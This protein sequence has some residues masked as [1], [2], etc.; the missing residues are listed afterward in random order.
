M[1]IWGKIIGSASG[2]AIGGPIGA[3]VGGIAGHAFDR[4]KTV[5]VNYEAKAGD[6]K[7]IAFTIAVIALGAKMAKADGRVTDDEIRAFR[8]VFKIP[9]GEVKNVGRV[10]NLARKDSRGFEPY[11]RQVAQ[12]F[13]HNSAVLEDLLDGLFHI[14]K[15][16]KVYDPLE[17]KFLKAVAEIFGF[18][19]SEFERIRESHLGPDQ[20]DPYTILGAKRSDSDEAIKLLYRHLVR[21]HHPDRLIAEGLPQEFID[22]ANS[23][24]ATINDAWDKIQN[25][26]GLR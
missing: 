25:E 6:I 18:S 16:D 9:I 2:F 24:L 8:E 10:F 1:S 4:S 26:R 13:S 22:I 7:Q 12:L 21:E 17:D 14:A 15:A 20:S 23:K 11:A 3:L 5:N 19:K